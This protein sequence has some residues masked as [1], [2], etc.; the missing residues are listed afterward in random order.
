ML[1]AVKSSLEISLQISFLRSM[2]NH[3]DSHISF[4]KNWFSRFKSEIGKNISQIGWH[5]LKLKEEGE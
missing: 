5:R 4:D 2:I 3:I 1:C